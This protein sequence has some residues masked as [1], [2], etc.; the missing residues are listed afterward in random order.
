MEG[1]IYIYSS[2]ILDSTFV[3]IFVNFRDLRTISAIYFG[4][5]SHLRN[6]GPFACMVLTPHKKIPSEMEVAPL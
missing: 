1:T 3:A 6:K 2:T 4:Q 5:N